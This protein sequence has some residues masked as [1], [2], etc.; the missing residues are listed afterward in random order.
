MNQNKFLASFDELQ[1][2]FNRLVNQG[3]LFPEEIKNINDFQ[4][5]ANTFINSKTINNDLSSNKLISGLPWNDKLFIDSWNEWKEYKKQQF[6]FTYKPISESKALEGL[7]EK[8][9][10]DMLIAIK[11]IKSSIQNSYTGLFN[12]NSKK[13][14]GPSTT[15]N[16]SNIDYDR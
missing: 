16:L 8:S 9:N 7:V 1:N 13:K 2:L 11:I 3:V 4:C 14:S 6:N 12:S 15:E 10:N 5:M